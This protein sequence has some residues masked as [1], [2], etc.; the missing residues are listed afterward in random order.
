MDSLV[1]VAGARELCSEEDLKNIF[2]KEGGRRLDSIMSKFFGQRKSALGDDEPTE[3]R[4]LYLCFF[5][6][7]QEEARKE[8]AAMVRGAVVPEGALDWEESLLRQRVQLGVVKGTSKEDNGDS[9]VGMEEPSSCTTE[10]T[11]Q[12]PERDG[13]TLI[14][15][16]LFRGSKLTGTIEG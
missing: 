14:S 3:D 2:R 6:A 9:G 5:P 1:L 12:Y 10:V 7:S 4:S 11:L 13:G 15:N 16:R 8:M